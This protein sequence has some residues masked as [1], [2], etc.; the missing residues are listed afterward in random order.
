MK[1]LWGFK[2]TQKGNLPGCYWPLNIGIIWSIWR[3]KVWNNDASFRKN[4]YIFWTKS[5]GK[6]AF[7]FSTKWTSAFLFF[8]QNLVNFLKKRISCSITWSVGLW[9][10]LP[11]S[12]FKAFRWTTF[13]STRTHSSIKGWE[14]AVWKKCICN[15]D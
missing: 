5:F 10:S 12:S 7:L 11:K 9:S 14:S 2:V 6:N 13:W 8:A 3:K 15:V 1:K 4:A